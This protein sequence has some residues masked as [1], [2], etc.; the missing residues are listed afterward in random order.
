MRHRRFHSDS[1]HLDLKLIGAG[2]AVASYV[3]S[4]HTVGGTLCFVLIA[5]LFGSGVVEAQAPDE[6]DFLFGRPLGSVS[7]RAG[8][9]FERAGSDLFDF[10]NKQLTIEPDDFDSPTLAFDLGVAL[11]SRTEAVFGVEF[12]SG[13]IRSEY[14]DLVDGDRLPITQAF[15]KRT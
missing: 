4:F 10:V 7:V 3:S 12:S 2:L 5:T 13:T 6:P 1:G 14:R 9:L 11:G 15:A 8:W